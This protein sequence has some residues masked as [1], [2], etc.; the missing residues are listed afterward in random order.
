[1]ANPDYPSELF[2]IVHKWSDH[3]TPDWTVRLMPDPFDS[4]VGGRDGAF[5]QSQTDPALKINWIWINMEAID[6][7]EQL[8]VTIV[9]ELL[10]AA[11]DDLVFPLKPALKETPRGLRKLIKRQHRAVSE[12]VIERL[13]KTLVAL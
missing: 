1:M 10:H 6:T 3:L 4:H 13:F 12:Q 7:D 9:H 2:R 5:G 8:E 11:V